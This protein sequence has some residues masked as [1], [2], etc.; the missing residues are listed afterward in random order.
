LTIVA[1][2]GVW[3]LSGPTIS[4][5]ATT[6]KCTTADLVVW[7]N[8]TASGAA[9]SAYYKINF[10]NLSTRSC[11]LEGYPGVL[12]LSLASTQLGSFAASNKAHPAKLFTLVSARTAKG[13]AA[14]NT[15]NS[16]T[17]ILQITD[18]GNFSAS[19]CAQVTAAGIGVTPPGQSA[20]RV[21]PYPFVACSKSG[22]RYLH[23]EA[24][25]KYVATQ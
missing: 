13:L 3:G 2:L 8:T 17:A 9:G 14:A 15:H 18:V 6:P 21:L 20:V 16:V 23:I 1:S 25:Q 7:L 19:A 11:T 12:G 22:P 24:I 10:T 5:A 4:S